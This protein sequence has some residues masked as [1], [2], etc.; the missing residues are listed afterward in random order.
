MKNAL[1]CKKKEYA[2]VGVFGVGLALMKSVYDY[3]SIT[4]TIMKALRD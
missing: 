4:K 1:V 3:E 2:C